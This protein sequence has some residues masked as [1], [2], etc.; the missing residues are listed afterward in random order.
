MEITDNDND[1]I[2]NEGDIFGEGYEEFLFNQNKQNSATA[3]KEDQNKAKKYDIFEDSDEDEDIMHPKSELNIENKKT[4]V[5]LKQENPNPNP[6][7]KFFIKKK[8][9]R[10]VEEEKKEKKK[11]AEFGLPKTKTEID[12]K[13]I[14]KKNKQNFDNIYNYYNDE[15]HYINMYNEEKNPEELLNMFDELDDI[16]SNKKKQSPGTQINNDKPEDL[17]MIISSLGNK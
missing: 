1:N 6:N 8:T 16:N 2:R 4:K 12:Y 10:P 17:D 14:K 3:K 7:Q 5:E 15:D 13:D 11:N 9:S